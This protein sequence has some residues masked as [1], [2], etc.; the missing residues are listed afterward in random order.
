LHLPRN[1][2]P[3]EAIQ[4]LHPDLPQI[5]CF[6]TAFHRT[7]PRVAQTYGLPRELTE[8]GGRRYGFHGLSY[9]YIAGKLHQIDPKTAGGRTVVAHLGSGASLCALREGQSVA[10]SMGFSPLSGLMMAT[11]PGELDPGLMVWLMRE[12]AMSIEAIEHM[13]YHDCGLR[14]VSGISG[15][16]RVLLASRSPE[17]LEA[18]DLFVYRA[19]Q[20]VAAMCAALEG[21]DTFVFTA[22][23]GEHAPEVR[24]RI[25]QRLEWLGLRLSPHPNA[26]SELYISAPDSAVNVL[27]IPTDEELMI[28]RHTARLVNVLPEVASRARTNGDRA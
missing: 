9:E 10:T 1:L 20:E 6:D 21:L 27:V 12:H 28:A 5:A 19:C 25:C 2:E 22:G 13:L 11:R 17:A 16:M 4:R 7:L 18:I 14:G 24:Q 3:I 23:I 26:R 15:D 8:L